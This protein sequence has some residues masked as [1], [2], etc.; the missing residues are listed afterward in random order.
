MLLVDDAANLGTRA[1]DAVAALVAAGAAAVAAALPGPLLLQ[2]VPLALQA[3]AGG[4][5]LVLSPRSGAEA[6]F[7]GVRLDDG[8]RP[9]G[10]AY[11]IGSGTAVPLQVAVATGRAGRH[12]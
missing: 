10:R 12:P 3:R 8:W 4:R 5:G 7:F 1:Q 11:R 9:P 2:Q 6:D